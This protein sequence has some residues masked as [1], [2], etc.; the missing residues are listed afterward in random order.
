MLCASTD[1]NRVVTKF[2]DNSYPGYT[3]G[4][5]AS[6]SV[7]G[8]APVPASKDDIAAGNFTILC[9]SG[10]AYSVVTFQR[11]MVVKTAKAPSPLIRQEGRV[12]AKYSTS[13]QCQH[14]PVCR[15]RVQA[16]DI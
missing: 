16:K 6:P 4:V 14:S 9:V 13:G 3:I 10:D 7:L 5:F 8:P 11:E 1:R 12:I 15:Q 2:G